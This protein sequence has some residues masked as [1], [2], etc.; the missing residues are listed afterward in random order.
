MQCAG[1]V[2][3]LS[4]RVHI[5]PSRLLDDFTPDHHQHDSLCLFST[6]VRNFTTKKTAG[7]SPGHLDMKKKID[8]PKSMLLRNGALA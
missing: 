1:H 7:V 8:T 4:S 5:H 2:P 6:M 3:T